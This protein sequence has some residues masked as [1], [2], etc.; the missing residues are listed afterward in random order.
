MGVRR[1]TIGLIG[2][3]LAAGSRSHGVTVIVAFMPAG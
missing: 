3:S 1:S 2:L